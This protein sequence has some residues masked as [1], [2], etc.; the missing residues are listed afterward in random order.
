M[1]NIYPFYQYCNDEVAPL[2]LSEIQVSYGLSVTNPVNIEQISLGKIFELIKSDPMIAELVKKIRQIN[3][4]KT[5]KSWKQKLPFFT[6]ALLRDAKNKEN[7]ISTEILI[8]DADHLSEFDF[9]RLRTELEGSSYTSVVFT[10]PSGNGLK[11][12]IRLNR[13]ITNIIE[14][15]TVYSRMLTYLDKQFNTHFDPVTRDAARACFLSH[16]PT[17]YINEN[18]DKFDIDTLLASTDNVLTEQSTNKRDEFLQMLAGVQ[19]GE[20]HNALTKVIG[21]CIAKGMDEKFIR[22]LAYS[23]NQ[24]NDPP[25][26]D[27]E[28]EL[29]FNSIYKSFSK[30][31]LNNI[32]FKIVKENKILID[33]AKLIEFLQQEGFCK[34][35][36]SESDYALARINNGII[37]CVGLDEIIEFIKGFVDQSND[38]HKDIVLD[39]LIRYNSTYFNAGAMKFLHVVTPKIKRGNK[40]TSFLYFKNCYLKITPNEIS[41][42]NYSENSSELIWKNSIIPRSIDASS[43]YNDTTPSIYSKMV[44][45]IC[46]NDNQ[47]YNALS[48]AIGYT[49]HDFKDKAIAKA[50]VF[51]DEEIP[52]ADDSNGGTGKSLVCEAIRYCRNTK[53]IDGKNIKTDSAFIFQQITN[54]TE[55]VIVDDVRKN[56]DFE[57]LFSVITSNITVEKKHKDPFTIPFATSPKFILTTNYTIKGNGNSFDRRKH[58]IEF[59]NYY[60]KKHS[61]LDDFGHR[62][63]DEWDDIEWIR[64]YR[65]IAEYIQNYLKNGLVKYKLRNLKIRRMIDQTSVQFLDFSQDMIKTNIEYNKKDLFNQF[66]IMNQEFSHLKE[67]TF[68]RWLKIYADTFDL[69]LEQRKSNKNRFIK[70]TVDA[71][72]I[73]TAS[74][75]DNYNNEDDSFEILENDNE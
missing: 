59:S 21:I 62:L 73:V 64:F 74:T 67:K 58:E 70:F 28:F 40:E 19:Q 38:P 43:F 50:V 72:G 1:T 14:Y 65:T 5:Q 24:L 75:V 49:L 33:S 48:C 11:L 10:S 7:F 18:A 37:S 20:R 46:R 30:N 51:C 66:K 6:G 68:S 52:T 41:V 29:E 12:I 17:I 34:I 61:P 45:N 13:Q 36:I 69:V 44:R 39:L 55:V 57:S 26:T 53:T 15:E 22:S 8:F 42:C 71:P 9:D 27:D 56:F 54:N 31:K 3:D 25:F 2:P 4:D 35:K 16:D 23:T 60:N 47:W 32:P 63:F